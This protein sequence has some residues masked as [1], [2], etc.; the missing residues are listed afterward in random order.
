MADA[1]ARH[2][3]RATLDAGERE[4]VERLAQLQGPSEWRAAVLAL[5]LTPGSQRERRAWQDETRGLSTART[6]YDAVAR[7]SRASPLPWLERLLKRLLATPLGDRQSLVEAARRVMSADGQ[8]RPID[9]LQWLALRH[10]LGESAITAA[11]PA[12]QHD[13]AELSLHTLREAARVTAFL[14]RLVPT[15]EAAAGQGW[16]LAVLAPWLPAQHL[17]ACAPPDAD[18]LVNALTEVQAMPWML[19]PVL[20]RA[21]LTQA[22]ALT[23]SRVLEPDAAD[24]LRLA[25]LLLDCPMPPELARHYVE[26]PPG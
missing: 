22:L 23:P 2:L 3:P 13:M 14:S 7:L 9:R 19:R 25:A 5:L 15:G 12:G 11:T 4:A 21:W 6:V 1:P 17:P 8:V 16:Y 10:R 20:V 26:P 24:A 18:G